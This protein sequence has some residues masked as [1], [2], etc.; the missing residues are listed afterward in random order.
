MQDVVLFG[1]GKIAEEVYWYFKADSDFNVVAFT[2]DADYIQKDSLFGLP[3][4]PF[5]SIVSEYP[6]D[7][8]KMF[9]AQG[10][11]DLNRLRTRKVAEV[12]SLGY[13]LVSYVS[14]RASNMAAVPV[15][16]N[17][18]VL[19]HTTIQPL[20]KVGSNVFLWSGNHLGH[21]AEIEDNCY[22]A[23][24]VV[25]GGNAV[26]GAG[27]LLG[28]NVTVGHNVHVGAGSI[29]GAGS[30]LTK[31]TEPG[32]VYIVKDT[33]RFRLDAEHFVKFTRM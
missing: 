25:I 2:A 13:S 21:H 27:S 10:Y 23:G 3:V 22:I 1:E 9:V 7:Q 16:E 4:R 20:T 11:Q 31:S 5:D 8:V 32:G 26:I 30:L 6:P 17:T 24:H 15:G 14:S 19:E 28:V 29:V 18:L 33:D 12:K